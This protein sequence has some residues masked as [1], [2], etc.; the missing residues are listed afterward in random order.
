MIYLAPLLT[1]TFAWSFDGNAA[2]RSAGCSVPQGKKAVMC[3]QE[4]TH[5]L[6]KCDSSLSYRAVGHELNMNESTGYIK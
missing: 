6:D 2:G 5:G 1:D 3:F 4:K